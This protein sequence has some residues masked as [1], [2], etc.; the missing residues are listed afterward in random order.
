MNKKK[1]TKRENIPP[2][3]RPAGYRQTVHLELKARDLANLDLV[4]A[5]MRRDPIV[6]LMDEDVTRARAARYAIAYCAKHSPAPNTT[7]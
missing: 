7:G 6:G 3:E 1:P 2:A 5:K 4:V